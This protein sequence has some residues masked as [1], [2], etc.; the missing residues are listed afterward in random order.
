MGLLYALDNQAIRY[1][2]RG[3]LVGHRAVVVHTSFAAARGGHDVQ[4][5]SEKVLNKNGMVVE[6]IAPYRL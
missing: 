1:E 4:Q 5:V 3:L 6:E 2:R